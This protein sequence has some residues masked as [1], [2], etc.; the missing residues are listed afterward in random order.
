MPQ[1]AN[2]QACPDEQHDAKGCL[3]QEQCDSHARPLKRPLARAGFEIAGDIS[4]LAQ[5]RGCETGEQRGDERRCSSEPE[6]ASVAQHPDFG[7][8]RQ[9]LRA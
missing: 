8:S 6:G 4:A 3:H 1:A 7:P 2:E 5:D 9:E